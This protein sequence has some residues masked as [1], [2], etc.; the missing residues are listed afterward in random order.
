[1]LMGALYRNWAAQGTQQLGFDRKHIT[2]A[3][4]R[5]PLSMFAT[6]A[7]TD[8]DLWVEEYSIGAVAQSRLIRI[9]Y[10]SDFDGIQRIFKSAKDNYRYSI[11]RIKQRSFKVSFE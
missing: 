5:Q 9:R 8:L 11:Y 4:E 3:S 7:S 10:N 1:M 6:L 2:P